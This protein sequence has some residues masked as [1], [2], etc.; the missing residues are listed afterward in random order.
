M[1]LDIPAN[2]EMIVHVN[3]PYASINASVTP[4]TITKHLS[5]SVYLNEAEKA[6]KALLDTRAMG[7]FIH[8]KVV[9]EHGLIQ[10]PRDPLPVLDMNGTKMGEL[11][12][13]VVVL[14]RIG[15]HEEK[16]T[17][18]ITP[19]GNHRIILGLPWFQT[20]NPTITYDTGHVQ[21]NSSCCNEHCLPQPHDVFAQQE[22]ISLTQTT[23]V[24]GNVCNMEPDMVNLYAI[25]LMLMATS[26]ELKKMVPE[27]YHDFLDVFDPEG[28]MREL[29]P[30]RPGYDFEIPLDPN[31]PLPKPAQ[32]YHM[33]P[34]EHEDWAK[35]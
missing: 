27:E 15:A 1:S 32:P 4:Y 35:W 18:N 6:H 31:K 24:E 22:P 12:F 20:H 7:N 10:M 25:D 33:N 28:P 30:L 26:E 5:I 13:Q 9:T 11:V 21:F 3:I 19:I 23:D 14:M 34:S 16:I 17:F 2:P 8:E 29:P